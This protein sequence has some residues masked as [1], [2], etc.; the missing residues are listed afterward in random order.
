MNLTVAITSKLLRPELP[1]FARSQNQRVCDNMASF[2]TD[3]VV[4]PY[5][6]FA[7][8]LGLALSSPTKYLVQDWLI[9]VPGTKLRAPLDL[10]S[11]HWVVCG[12]GRFGAR[13]AKVLE[14]R[15]QVVTVVDT[16]DPVVTAPADLTVELGDSVTLGTA[17]WVDAEKH[18]RI[19]W[20]TT[21]RGNP[22][23]EYAGEAPSWIPATA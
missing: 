19:M 4:N 9:S 7:R 12:L 20:R 13:I 11:G 15:N 18:H 3:G 23:P 14:D 21:V 17:T 2:R 16:T 10:P 22:G 5:D 6:I 8:R 1:V